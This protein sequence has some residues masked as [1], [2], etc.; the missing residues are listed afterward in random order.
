MTTNWKNIFITY[1]K[2][3][4]SL[5]YKELLKA[6]IREFPGGLAVRI[7]GFHCHGW[8]SIPDRGTEIPQATWCSQKLTK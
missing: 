2:R 4:S 6:T 3:L 1:D 7:L 8:G 5:I